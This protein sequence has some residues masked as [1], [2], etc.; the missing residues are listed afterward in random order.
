MLVLAVA[1]LASPLPASANVESGSRDVYYPHTAKHAIMGWNASTRRTYV[2]AIATDEYLGN[3]YC[4]DSWFD[5]TT[6]EGSS[7][8][9]ARGARNCRSRASMYGDVITESYPVPGMQ[10]AGL[11]YGPDNN[12]KSFYYK[13]ASGT[14]ISINT[15]NMDFRNNFS[16][17]WW[18]RSANNSVSTFSGGNPRSPT[19]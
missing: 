17:R 8:F 16:I 2:D 14:D 19:S 4:L 1:V 10:K 3:G 6:P 5:W 15:I 18:R 11:A 12:T 7:H 9:D 13:D